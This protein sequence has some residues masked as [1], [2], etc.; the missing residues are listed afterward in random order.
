CG[1]SRR[2]GFVVVTTRRDQRQRP[3]PDLVNRRFAADGPD[4]LWVAD[5]PYVPTWAGFL[6]LSIVLDVWSRRVVG[7]AMGEL[8][9]AE[10]VLAA[11]NMALQQRKPNG[12]IHHSDQGSQLG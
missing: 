5:L 2:R 12:V 7:W 8:M 9:T 11:L 1:V 6:Y 4:Q 10:L 3:A